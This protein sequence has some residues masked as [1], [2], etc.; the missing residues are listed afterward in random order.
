MASHCSPRPDAATWS[1]LSGPAYTDSP[2]VCVP[3][4]DRPGPSSPE[5]GPSTC[6]LL[7]NTCTKAGSWEPGSTGQLRVCSRLCVQCNEP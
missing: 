3:S 4:A 7:G 6:T 2:G 5:H 1:D